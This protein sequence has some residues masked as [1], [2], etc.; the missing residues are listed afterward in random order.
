MKRVIAF[1]L[2]FVSIAFTVQAQYVPRNLNLNGSIFEDVTD[3]SGF[4]HKGHG[5]CISLAD[6]DMDGN[7]DIYM[8]TVYAENRF[9][10]NNGSLRFKDITSIIRLGGGK[11]DTHGI[12]WADF[13]NNG[14]LDVFSANNLEA[15][16]QQRGEVLHPNTFFLAGDEGFIECAFKSGLA[17]NKFNYSC[18]VTTADVNGDGLLDIYVSEGGYR[19]GPECANSLYV[20]NGDGTYRDIAKAAGVAHEGNGYC[21]A[22][23]DYDNDGDPDL[24][25]GNINNTTDPVTFA[26]FRNNGNGKFTDVTAELGL[27][28]RGNNLPCFWGDTDND[29]DQD[30]F[31][32]CSTGPGHPEKEW[33]KN[34]LFRNNG[35]GTFTDVS[36]Q[37]GVEVITNSRGSSMGDI[38][39][40]GDLDIIVTNSWYD[41]LVF[42]NDGRGKF[43]ESHEKTGGSWFYGHGIALGDLDNDGDLDLV[44]GNWRRPS[45]SNPGKWFLFRNNTDNK[46]FIKV[47]VKGTESNR[48]AVMSKVW[49]YDTGRTGNRNALRGYREVTAGNGTFPGNPLQQH[50][51]V[52]ASK[53]YDIVVKF[54]SGIES[55]L[56][57]VAAGRTYNIY[58]TDIDPAKYERVRRQ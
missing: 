26:L 49:I 4:D 58:E 37:A 11:L 28:R 1:A 5:K 13:D 20:N 36:T 16:S 7:L 27:A 31:L 42:I 44:G 55:I 48:S 56:K 22:F 43:T 15:L 35:D 51:G 46:N 50:F 54:P 45:A 34:I 53:K 24:C 6:F 32:A 41:A 47:N 19:K 29:G 14:Y 23:S 40:D 8:S 30:L 10:Q 25:V 3:G 21:C 39:N 18:G 9:F 2:V 38:D 52:N 33:G 12:V 17:G 57:N